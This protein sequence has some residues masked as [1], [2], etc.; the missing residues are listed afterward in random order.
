M[1]ITSQIKKRAARSSGFTLLE[2]VIMTL[3]LSLVAVAAGV[4][5]QSLVKVPKQNDNQLVISN[6]MVDRMEQLRGTAFASLA[7]GSSGKLSWSVTTVDPTG[8][9]SP[10]SDFKQITVTQD[11]R[12]ISCYVTKP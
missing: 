10:K 11:G 12:S 5:L 9:A 4:G 3:I 2:A 6:Q 7:S 1:S 8:G